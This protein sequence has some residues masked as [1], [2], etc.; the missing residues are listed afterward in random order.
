MTTTQNSQT[1]PTPT[2]EPGTIFVRSWGYDQ[3]NIDFYEIT[4]VS[5]TGKTA[6]ARKILAG[7]VD[8]S[9]VIAATGDNRFP[10][11]PDCS[12]CGNQHRNVDGQPDQAAQGW[13]GH[14]FTDLYTWQ[15]RYDRVTTSSYDHAYRWDGEPEYVTPFGFGH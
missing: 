3:T 5:K 2:V 8:D 13:D 6:K 7:H 9:H 10:T 11:D 15:A 12:R 1:A 4:E 14:P